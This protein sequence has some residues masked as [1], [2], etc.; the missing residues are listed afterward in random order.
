MPGFILVNR[1]GMWWAFSL[2]GLLPPCELCSEPF[3]SHPWVSYFHCHNWLMD[4]TI[5]HCKCTWLV[6]TFLKTKMATKSKELSP[7]TIYENVLEG[8]RRSCEVEM[9]F[10][11]Q[12]KIYGI[13]IH[14]AEDLPYIGPDRRLLAL[15]LIWVSDT[16]FIV[17][18]HT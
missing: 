4:T 3:R 9:H 2:L 10:A 13:S 5:V 7:L 1:P 12:H 6:T 18:P 17:I 8:L 11:S 15:E 16:F 14:F